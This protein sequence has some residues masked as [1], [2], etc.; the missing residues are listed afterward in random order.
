MPAGQGAFVE[1][2]S[3][4]GRFK[5]M[6]NKK[7]VAVVKRLYVIEGLS[8][9]ATAEKIGCSSHSTVQKLLEKKGWIRKKPKLTK[10]QEK[11]A[12]VYYVKQ[13]YS[14]A[15]SARCLDVTQD[16]L[17]AFLEREKLLRNWSEAKK[18]SYENGCHPSQI[19]HYNIWDNYVG[20]D[21]TQLS[22]PQYLYAARKFTNVVLCR[23]KDII[24]PKNKR[25]YVNHVDHLF[26]IKNAYVKFDKESQVFIKRN[27]ILPLT[28]V[29]HPAN[30]K[31]VDRRINLA[32]GSKCSITLK[33]LKER[34]AKFEAEH[35]LVF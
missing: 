3:E 35:G 7:N 13:K 5:P 23:Y 9:R 24:D 8:I 27:K 17:L 30:L 31:V 28:I 18:A 10:L 1:R 6:W 15:Q 11:L 19:N 22:W 4:T 25:S 12:R 20:I 29:C 14:L 2:D 21:I 26:S 16:V 34:I 33:R 32:K